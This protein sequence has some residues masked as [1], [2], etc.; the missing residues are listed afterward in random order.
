MSTLLFRVVDVSCCSDYLTSFVYKNVCRG[1]F[2]AHKLLFSFLISISILRN[3]GKV[4][5]ELVLP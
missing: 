2:E 1:L 4:S 3:E 5:T